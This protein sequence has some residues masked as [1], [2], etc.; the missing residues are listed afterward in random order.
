MNLT[1]TLELFFGGPGS[2]CN[3]QAGKCGRIASDE[4]D[5]PKGWEKKVYKLAG[6]P[7][8]LDTLKVRHDEGV[9]TWVHGWL[10]AKGESVGKDIMHDDVLSHAGISP[11]TFLEKS[12][13]LRVSSGNYFEYPLFEIATK[14]TPQQMESLVKIWNYVRNSDEWKDYGITYEASN[15]LAN[16]VRSGG[17]G[18][19]DRTNVNFK[20]S[21]GDFLRDLDKVYG[22]AS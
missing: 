8:S 15:H 21:W 1:A 17:F 10:N 2:G 12:G 18:A 16:K 4:K 3:P 7:Q 20:H 13:W 9:E 11:S 14:P 5:L 19:S 22:K 6:K